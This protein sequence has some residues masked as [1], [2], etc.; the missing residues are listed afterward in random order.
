M[1]GNFFTEVWKIAI[2]KDAKAS[3]KR[4]AAVALLLVA[5]VVV[6]GYYSA[7]TLQWWQTPQTADVKGVAPDLAWGL[8][9]GSM[10][11]L[12]AMIGLQINGRIGGALIDEQNLMSLSRFQLVAWTVLVVSAFLTIAL[13]RAFSGVNDALN[14]TVPP[15]L[16]KLLGITSASAVG[17]EVVHAMKKEKQPSN[18]DVAAANS[19][20]AINDNAK[21]AAEQTNV[22]EIELHRAGTLYGNPKPSD[23]SFVDMFQGVEV[24]NTAYVDMAKVQMFFFT[25]AAIVAYASE[26]FTMLATHFANHLLTAPKAATLAQLPAIGSGLLAILTISHATYLGAKSIDHTSTSAS[27]SANAAAAVAAN[28]VIDAPGEQDI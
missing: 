12:L 15:E 22:Q 17:R 21:S 23:A 10:I 7:R 3:A 2:A 1:I 27:G 4:L 14:I 24:G 20:A 11:V 9:A 25:I 26:V 8:I 13:I 6:S 16:W 18:P 5:V 19:A 28:A